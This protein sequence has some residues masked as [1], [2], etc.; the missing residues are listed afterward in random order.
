MSRSFIIGIITTIA[1]AIGLFVFFYFSYIKT[2]SR[3]IHEAIP[4]HAGVFIES[5]DWN[6]T[7]EL[8]RNS[9]I[10]EGVLQNGQL[11]TAFVKL[12]EW[13]GFVNKQPTFKNILTD[14]KFALSLHNLN[15]KLSTLLVFQSDDFEGWDAE[16]SNTAAQM[17][18]KVKQRYFE[19]EKVYDLLNETGAIVLSAVYTKGFILFSADGVLVED[20]IRKLKYNLTANWQGIDKLYTLASR[21]AAMQVYINYNH[22]DA[23]ISCFG[24]N[25]SAAFMTNL[26]AW[27]M[28]DVKIENKQWLLSG[29]TNTDDTAYQFL[30]VFTAQ[31]PVEWQSLLNYMPENTAYFIQTGFDNYFAYQ[32]DLN[33]FLRTNNLRD[34]I[35]IIKNLVKQKTGISLEDYSD[36]FT[37]SSA[38]FQTQADRVQA[39]NN[40]I[41]TLGNTKSAEALIS[42]LHN[43]L[44]STDSATFIQHGQSKIYYLPAG[45]L[46]LPLLGPIFEGIQ[47]PY[48][49]IVNNVAVWSNTLKELKSILDKVGAKKVLKFSQ[50]FKSN[51]VLSATSAN[52]SLYF[53]TS[54]SINQVMPHLNSFATSLINRYATDIKKLNTFHIQYASTDDK[55]FYTH[56]RLLY[57]ANYKEE[58]RQLWQFEPDTI[59]ARVP[60]FVEL[61]DGSLVLLLQDSLKNLYMLNT[62]GEVVWKKQLSAFLKGAIHQ[63][64]LAPDWK[65]TLH[66]VTQDNTLH[67]LYTDGKEIATY[68]IKLPGSINGDLVVTDWYQ[69]SSY[70]ITVLLTNNKML[71]YTPNGRLISGWNPVNISFAP[72]SELKSVYIP[73]K[74][75]Q[76]ILSDDNG[77]TYFYN[78]A[79]KSQKYDQLPK[80]E[81]TPIWVG[82]QEALYYWFADSSYNLNVLKVD[83][84]LLNN[85]TAQLPSVLNTLPIQSITTLQ[86]LSDR[87]WLRTGN[88]LSVYQTSGQLIKQVTED[89]SVA[90]LF[91]QLLYAKGSVFGYVRYAS[92]TTVMYQYDGK[93]YEGFPMADAIY[94]TIAAEPARNRNLACVIDGNRNVILYYIR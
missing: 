81:V 73:G 70:Q 71:A 33:E 40:A 47:N 80:S 61:A 45:Q 54:R 93:T 38:I 14:S 26:A 52:F 83:T 22:I 36:L 35:T 34:S 86:T 58:S 92:S 29:I 31:K 79:A 41:T 84:S 72:A 85:P 44:N 90:H 28:L 94:F 8:L 3:P 74:G 49:T 10:A 27:T 62:E 82:D 39:S 69:D 59:L 9:H 63:A 25:A 16:L 91:S 55:L 42:Q 68:P 37:G 65:Q 21:T 19:K 76:I 30:D 67:G 87:V 77:V 43:R 13:V 12:Q 5:S 18:L 17:K 46:L 15:G 66:F 1:V 32:S 7:I 24:K 4:N 78:K 48:V 60:Q 2:P 6:S 75:S 56:V 50:D 89:D 51:Q 23:L 53:N 64:L 11:N 20:A 88:Q 57:D